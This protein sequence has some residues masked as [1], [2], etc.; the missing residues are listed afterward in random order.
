[1]STPTQAARNGDAEG[2]PAADGAGDAK[3]GSETLSVTDN[4]TGTSYELPIEDGTVRAMD[5][6]QIKVDDGDFGLMAYDPAYTNTASCRSAI[7]YI[8]GDAGILQHRGYPL[9]QLCE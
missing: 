6:R 8:D 9:E 7:T 4:R 3:A 1:M 2:R 5:L